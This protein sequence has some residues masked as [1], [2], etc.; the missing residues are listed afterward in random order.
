MSDV[1]SNADQKLTRIGA[2]KYLGVSP[3]FL[4]VDVVNRRHG[5]PFI[6]I[7]RRCVYSRKMLD[8]YIAAHTVGNNP[9]TK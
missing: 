6:K 5:I 9:A 1:I 8:A 2:A 3:S 7:G 4:A